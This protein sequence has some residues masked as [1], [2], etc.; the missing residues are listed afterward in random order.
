ME[1]CPLAGEWFCNMD[2]TLPCSEWRKLDAYVPR[3]SVSRNKA[4]ERARREFLAWQSIRVFAPIAYEAIGLREPARQLRRFRGTLLDASIFS[5]TLYMRWVCIPTSTVE[6]NVRC[7]AGWAMEAANTDRWGDC[8]EDNQPVFP[9]WRSA[10]NA[11]KVDM[12]RAYRAMFATL[13]GLLRTT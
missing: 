3:V 6:M 13:D 7:A 9:A 8:T 5:I 4:A 12:D 2:E 1:P 11:A 10:E